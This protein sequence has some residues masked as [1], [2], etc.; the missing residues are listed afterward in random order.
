MSQS[1]PI[2]HPVVAQR[3]TAAS[4]APFGV[5]A[6][7]PER[8]PEWTASGSRLAGVTEAHQ[9]AADIAKLWVVGELEFAAPIFIGSVRYFHKGFEVAELERHVGETQTW[10]AH[11][12]TSLLVV[13]PPTDRG[14][15][16]NPADVRIFIVEPGDVLAIGRGVWM[17]HFFPLGPTADY[18]VISARREPELDR[19][20]VNLIATRNTVVHAVFA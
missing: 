19:D 3:L 17:C 7:R 11:S 10:V 8:E 12:G 2:A 15:D 20:L 14:E 1:E 16:L 18:S 6:E 9:N 5:F 13:A 4:F